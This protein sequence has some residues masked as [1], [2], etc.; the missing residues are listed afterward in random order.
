M[1]HCRTAEHVANL[2]QVDAKLVKRAARDIRKEL[3]SA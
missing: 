3:E 1:T 2:Y